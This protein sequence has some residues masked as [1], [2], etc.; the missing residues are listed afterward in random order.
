VTALLTPAEHERV[1]AAIRAAEANTSGE[2][3]AVAARA[4]DGDRILPVLWAALATL[5]GGILAG[6]LWPYIAALTSGAPG[7]TAQSDDLAPAASSA[8]S[9]A[10]G[11]AFVFAM[12]AALSQIPKLRSFFVPRRLRERRTHRHA[13]EQ[14]LA[15]NLHATQARTGVLVFVSVA[16]R[17]AIVIADKGIHDRVDPAVWADIVR[18]LTAQVAEG[19]LSDGL[20]A[21]IA[22]CGRVLAEHFPPGL[23]D[24]NEL[25]DRLVEI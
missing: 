10:A 1:A 20:T 7:W 18:D 19:R 8:P 5:L 16:E 23:S 25:P 12:L 11:Q 15:H 13:M 3:F 22:A 6:L 24:E 2:I 4:S 21:A 14:F 17:T 9:L